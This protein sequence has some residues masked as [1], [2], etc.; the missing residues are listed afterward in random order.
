M[1]LSDKLVAIGGCDGSSSLDSI[2]VY[3]PELEEWRLGPNM[4][5]PRSNV[6]A[7][8]LNNYLYAI[9]GFSGT[10]KY[11]FLFSPIRLLY[12]NV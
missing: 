11:L 5:I 6:G 9:G 8:V 12:S 2:E 3:D 1:L 4:T 10:Y 7:A